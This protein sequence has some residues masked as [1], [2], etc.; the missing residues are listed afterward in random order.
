MS[1]S[2][3]RQTFREIVALVTE[4][5]KAKLPEAVNGRVESAAKLV[6]LHDVTPQD[7]GSIL[8]GS[9]SDPGKQ[10]RLVGLTCE[11]QDFA[12]GKAPE[13][14]CAHRIAAGIA[15]RVS[16]VLGNVEDAPSAAGVTPD[17]APVP[18]SLPEA[19][20]SA[21]VRLHV[22]GHD[23]Q[24]TLRDHDEAQLLARLRVLLEQY[25]TP[26]PPAGPQGQGK[27]WCSL[28]KLQMRWNEG[29]EGRQGWY[30]H[31]TPEGWCKGK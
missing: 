16:E 7:D 13:G 9:A 19:R 5:A 11:C 14:W 6:L 2:T 29:K 23:V 15:K 28:H 1:T 17:T 21:N 4:K 3:D 25:P 31:K 20:S 8:V 12:Y 30:S 18:A 27:D 26:Q 10:Y 22:C 24:V